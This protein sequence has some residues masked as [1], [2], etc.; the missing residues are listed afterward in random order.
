MFNKIAPL[1]LV[2]ATFAAPATVLASH[3]EPASPMATASSSSVERVLAGQKCRE[4][5]FED[6]AEF[7]F[8]YGRGRGALARCI[9][10]EIRE[11]HF[12]CRQ[13]AREDPYDFREE[14]GAG[15]R[16]HARC[17]RDQLS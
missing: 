11:A 5:A 12:D 3:G 13:D 9:R 4:K 1:A 17:V 10:L 8:D 16:A 2:T 14:H 6:R 15:S 7:R